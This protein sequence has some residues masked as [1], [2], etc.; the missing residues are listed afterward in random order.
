MR[1]SGSISETF[2]TEILK[3][4]SEI[5]NAVNE[6]RNVL[7]SMNSILEE[8][9]ELINNLQDRIMENNWSEQ[10]REKIIMQNENRLRKFS[11]RRR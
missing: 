1:V 11:P 7:D 6:M 10:K 3:S 2:N 9:E 5:K 4:Q 8:A